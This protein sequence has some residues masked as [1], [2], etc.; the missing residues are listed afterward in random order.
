MNN[1]SI[2]HWSFIIL[3]DTQIYTY[4][5]NNIFIKQIEWINNNIDILNIKCVLH[6]GD[7]TEL[8]SKKEWEFSKFTLNKLNIPFILAIGNHDYETTSI[9]P[10]DIKNRN[11]LFNDYFPISIYNKDFLGGIYPLEPTKTENIYFKFTNNNQKWLII[12]LEF[13]PRNQIIEWANTII[14]NNI[15]YKVILLTHAYLYGDNNRYDWNKYGNTQLDTPHSYSIAKNTNHNINDGEE[16]WNKLVKINSNIV[17]TI[18]GHTIYPLDFQLSNKGYKLDY[19][20]FHKKVHQMVVNYQHIND[21]KTGY[22]RI[23]KIF[24]DNKIHFYD[25]S[26]ILNEFNLKQNKILYL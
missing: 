16:L 11:T 21:M 20:N 23:V 22:L 10:G 8:N 3:P 7:I 24:D 18:N 19:N 9:K 4:K 5:Y 26:P 6:T 17:L 25:Y 14:S 2:N 15:D 12:S 1:N 13:A